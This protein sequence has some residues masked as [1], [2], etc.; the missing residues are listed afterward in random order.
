M[1]SVKVARR[2]HPHETWQSDVIRAKADMDVTPAKAE[3]QP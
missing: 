1:R 2:R 3:I